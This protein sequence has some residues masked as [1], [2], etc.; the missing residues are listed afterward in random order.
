MTRL[1]FDIETAETD[2]TPSAVPLLVGYAVDD[3]PVIVL[4][5]RE[6]EA[7]ETNRFSPAAYTLLDLLADPKVTKVE[8]TKFDVRWLRLAGWEVCGPIEDTA[9]MAY[10]LNENTP[11]DL[12]WLTR[13][14]SGIEM[15]KRLKRS[16]G[17]VSFRYVIGGFEQLIPLSEMRNYQRDSQLWQ[18]FSEYNGRDVEALRTLHSDLLGRLDESEWLS[19]WQEE[20]VPYTGVLARM[21]LRGLPIN[22]EEV[23]ELTAELEPLAARQRDALLGGA[24]LPASFNLN[25]QKQLGLYLFSR[26]LAFSDR[27]PFDKDTIDCFKSCLAGEHEDC[28]TAED[29]PLVDLVRVMSE[30]FSSYIWHVVDLL[31]E[32]FVLDSVGNGY[33]HGHWSVPGR[34]HAE[35]PHTVNKVT[36]EQSK[37]P[38]VASPDLLYYLGRDPW[39]QEMCTG[40]RKTNKVL[41][42][43][44]RTFPKAARD[45]RL[46]GRYNQT[47][48]VTGRLSSSGPNLQNQPARGPLG[49]KVR[50]LYQGNFVIGDYDQ[51]EMRLMAHFSGDARMVKVFADGGDPHILTMQGIFGDVDPYA[52]AAGASLGYRD[53]AKQINY[54][55][56]YGAGPKKVAQT[57]SLF[58]FPT[59]PDTAKGYLETAYKFYRGFFKWKETEI[60]LA[61]RKGSVR[62]LGGHRRRLRSAFKDVSNWKLVGYGE[63]QAINAIIQGTAADVIRRAMVIADELYPNL[64]MLAQVHDEVI[65]EYDVFPS[66]Y[67]LGELQRTFEVDHGFDLRVPLVFEP[68]VCAT[69]ADKG[70]QSEVDLIEDEEEFDDVE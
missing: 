67:L 45:G 16:G 42:T 69:W 43:Y 52:I 10:V 66:P 3:G 49:K 6:F 29:T 54:A 25:S 70:G 11:L 39:V 38:S 64:H 34:G 26:Q 21:E 12:E 27:L 44:L 13:R 8:H 60:A 22:L 5:D 40:F 41:T 51:L 30:D 9:V 68:H 47:G 19:Y 35:T 4:D 37:Y 28:G 15:D 31:P 63:R 55:M 17:T 50:H 33:V 23:A 2:P 36:G 65:F 14:Y 24:G 59:T 18:Q 62:T 1:F 48:T 46:Y 57:L 7:D 32:G 20:Q 58:G 61:K 56:G 53:A